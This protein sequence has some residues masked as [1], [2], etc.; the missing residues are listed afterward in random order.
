MKMN[1]DVHLDIRPAPWRELSYGSAGIFQQ[2]LT[3]S[4]RLTGFRVLATCP[5]WA[6]TPKEM[7]GCLLV[8]YTSA[9]S[10]LHHKTT[11]DESRCTGSWTETRPW[12][13]SQGT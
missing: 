1:F 2:E 13:L 9:H 10:R 7:M 3:N 6:L 11:H 5:S 8:K 4:M 12:Q